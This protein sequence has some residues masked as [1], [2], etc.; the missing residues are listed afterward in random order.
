[1]ILSRRTFLLAGSSLLVG[2]DGK[3]RLEGIYPILQSPFTEDNKLD[4]EDLA[5]Q[6]KFCDRCGCHGVVWPQLA[7]EY[8]SLTA[9]ER[10]AGME[11]MVKSAKGL[12]PK[13]VLGVQGKD[14]E[15]AL[16]YVA[17]ANKVQPDA[18]IALPPRD[19]KDNKIIGEYYRAIGKASSL[20]LFVQAIGNMSIDFILDMA[21]DVPT[22]RYLKDE[23]SP[24]LPRISEWRKRAPEMTIF[25]GGHGKT[26]LDEMA[27]GAVGTMPAA[28]FIDLY[29]VI[30]DLWHAG[31][32]QEAFEMY[33]RMSAMVALI[34]AYGIGSIKFLLVERGVFKT[35]KVRQT[36]GEESFDEEARKSLREAMNHVRRY[37]KA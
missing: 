24:T 34:S 33:G 12:K 36:R 7:S 27:R 37:F 26:M 13:V 28:A 25:T 35:W 1:M 14:A 15:E 17:V 10:F 32:K 9:E 11:T 16:R 4:L 3:T 21:K 29:V 22:L 31:R 2:A 20:P 5:K 8:A 18:I 19:V 23:A 30:W 6:V